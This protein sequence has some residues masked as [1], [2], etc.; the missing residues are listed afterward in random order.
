M[1]KIILLSFAALSLTAM[2]QHV[3]PVSIE[4][5][6]VKLDSLR[7]LYISEPMMYRTA[8]DVV[9]RDLA[10]N[11]D[12]LKAA[13]NELKVEQAHAKEIESSIKDAQKMAASLKKLYSKEESEIKSMQKTVEKQ[14]KTLNKHKELNQETRESYLNLLEKQQK[15]LGY[16]VREV[17]ER[18]HA[19]SDLETTL[20]NA[21]TNLQAYVQET[22]QK[23]LKLTEIEAL[24]KERTTVIKAEQKS[25]KSMQ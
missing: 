14:Q 12:E 25:A 15:E 16:S 20:Q 1:K 18:L 3:T 13:K 23:G 10:K 5:A 9:A 24:I 2:A 11:A 8:L 6:E 7:A 19:V 21:Q 17:A 22:Q 4:V